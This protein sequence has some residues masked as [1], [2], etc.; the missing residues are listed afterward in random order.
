MSRGFKRTVLR[1]EGKPTLNQPANIDHVATVGVQRPARVPE[2]DGL[3]GIAILAVLLFH[4]GYFLVRSDVQGGLPLRSYRFLTAYGWAGVDLFFVLSGYLISGILSDS[5]ASADYF[6]TFYIRRALRIFPLYYSFL[7]GFYCLLPLF[8]MAMG[9]SRFVQAYVQPSTQVFAWLYVVNWFGGTRHFNHLPV[10]IHHFWSLSVEEQ[11]YFTW[12]ALMKF[13]SRKL[14]KRICLYLFL[15]SLVFRVGFELAGWNVAANVWTVCRLDGIAIGS[16]IAVSSR[17]HG[18]WLH[19][20]LKRWSRPAFLICG[21]AF[22]ILSLFRDSSVGGFLMDTFGI[23]L[24]S[25]LF[26]LCVILVIDYKSSM[27]SRVC[28]SQLLGQLG[29]YSYGAY[30]LHQPL[31]ILLQSRGFSYER[32]IGVVQNEWLALFIVNMVPI[33]LTAGA[34]FV[35]WHV[36]EKRFLRLKDG[37]SVKWVRRRQIVR[38]GLIDSGRRIC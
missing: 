12:P 10:S 32:I 24:L 4:I 21:A 19:L 28:S 8:L 13:F 1:L 33:V 2:L 20:H 36:L 16:F 3:R 7:L 37:F 34:A 23:S 9:R 5:A 31:I 14:V 29:M 26:G 35:S 25:I 6:R 38:E 30:V 22:G 18:S 17:D 11:F 15:T 27:I